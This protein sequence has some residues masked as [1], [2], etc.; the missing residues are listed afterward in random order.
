MNALSFNINRL[1]GISPN[2]CHNVVTIPNS[3]VSGITTGCQRVVFDIYASSSL[4][5]YDLHY[6][7][8]FWPL[9]FAS[10]ASEPEGAFTVVIPPI[11]K[12]EIK[13][14]WIGSGATST[15]TSWTQRKYPQDD[16][17]KQSPECVDGVA[18]EKIPLA[19]SMR[20]QHSAILYRSWNFTRD[21]LNHAT[22]CNAG[23]GNSAC[24]ESCLTDA[25]CMAPAGQ[26]WSMSDYFHAVG[27]SSFW[28]NVRFFANDD[29]FSQS[30]DDSHALTCP[31]ACCGE[32]R[33]CMRT[34]DDLGQPVPFDK[35]YMLVFG[36]KTRQKVLIDEVDLYL[37]CEALLATKNQTTDQSFSSCYE[38]NSEELWRL[39]IEQDTW[40]LLKPRSTVSKTTDT[41]QI[42]PF[43]RFGHAAALVQIDAAQDL[44]NTRRQFMF[45]FGGYSINCVNGL[46]LDL[47]RYEIPWAAQAYWPTAGSSSVSTYMRGNTWSRLKDSP[48]GGIY[49]HTMVATESGSALYVY[50]G[51]QSGTYSG[52]LLVYTLASDSWEK[53]EP[54]GYR[55]FT[56]SVVEYLGNTKE[57][58]LSDFEN[59]IDSP[60]SPDQPAA[61]S[62]SAVTYPPQFPAQRGDHS[63]VMLTDSDGKQKAVILN[64]FRTYD[65]PYPDATRNPYP[66]LP[67]YLDDDLWEYSLDV[68]SWKRIFFARNPAWSYPAPRRGAAV[69]L[70]PRGS[71]DDVLVAVG[72][73]QADKLYSDMWTMDVQRSLKS[74]R[75]W[76]RIDDRIAGTPPPATTFHS[77]VYDDLTGNLIVFGGLKWTQSDLSYSDTLTDVDRRCFMGARSVLIVVCEVSEITTYSASSQSDCN[78]KKAKAEIQSK[79]TTGSSSFCCSGVSQFGT[80]NSLTALNDLCTTKCQV[81]SFQ[82]ELSLGFGEGVWFYSPDACLNSCSGHGTCSMSQCICRPGWTGPDCSQPLCLGSFC[83]KNSV[84]LNTDCQFCSGNGV[85]GTTGSCTCNAGWTGDDCSMTT[86][87]PSC[88]GKGQCLSEFPINQCICDATYSGDSC[89]S[90]LCLNLCSNAGTCGTDGKCICNAGFYGDDCSVYMM[91]AS[92][93][94]IITIASILPIILI[95]SS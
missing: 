16:W 73:S 72:G 14:T 54:V 64:G 92:A 70:I 87:S 2:T 95:I 40:E 85:C 59:F 55:Y 76:Q 43:G 75:V 89:D 74:E 26:T 79:C 22:L 61:P 3:P 62:T 11:G 19:P 91:T 32:R 41:T 38:F 12:E 10:E 15:F 47:W 56:R 58:I 81:S 44:Q 60:D 20:Y 65:L 21:V 45:V 86:C 80:I 52:H 24:T 68:N 25:T 1:D 13:Y 29:G 30:I 88:S 6:L 35:S 77:A 4:T 9:R 33:L 7:T 27:D 82:S 78:L 18:C 51:Q 63:C 28:T 8:T 46:C 36:G 66:T 90:K 23:N 39:D 5:K 93:T 17:V 48:F 50:G 71:A 69:V 84:S 94:G 42:F 31:S 53:K 67:Y 57:T 83:Y 49:R 37:H 34:R